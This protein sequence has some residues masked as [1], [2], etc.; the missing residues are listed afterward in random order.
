M[1]LKMLIKNKLLWL[2]FKTLPLIKD[3]IFVK[4]NF[5][6]IYILNFSLEFQ[7]PTLLS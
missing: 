5:E 3:F 6:Y 1:H 2:A 7:V 4:K